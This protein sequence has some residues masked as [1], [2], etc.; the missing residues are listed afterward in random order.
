MMYD[1]VDAIKW[2][3]PTVISVIAL[4]KSTR[5]SKRAQF[6]NSARTRQQYNADL[7]SWANDCIATLCD[8]VS[9]ARQIEIDGTKLSDVISRLSAQVDQ[10]RLFFPNP[11]L[12]DHDSDSEEA[13]QGYRPRVLDWLF[14]GFEVCCSIRTAPD[15]EAGAAL[16]LLQRGFT[17]DAQIAIDPRNPSPTMEDLQERLKEGM[18]T[19]SFMDTSQSHKNLLAARAL[20]DTRKLLSLNLVS[21]VTSILVE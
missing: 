15:P 21:S 14:F 1:P 2:L 8:A 16:F 19:D 11:R 5:D 4:W 20:I 10:G 18:E 17:T 9:V 13:F 3:V 6:E 12:D 7:R